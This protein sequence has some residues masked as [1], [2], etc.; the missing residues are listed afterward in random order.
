MRP[1]IFLDRDGVII[2]NRSD[3]VKSCD[4]VI[5]IPAA[6]RGLRQIATSDYAIV[7]VTNQAAVGK[8]IITLVQA[9]EINRRVIKVVRAHGGRI[10]AA[11]LCPHRSDADCEC[12]KPK[13]GM[14]LRAA[15]DQGLDLS[16]S[17]MIGDA[18]TDMQTARAAGVRGILVRTGQ[19]VIELERCTQPVWFG[20][21]DDLS[22][23]LSSIHLGTIFV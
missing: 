16:S 19:G 11:Y 5:L 4:E 1:A 18:I 22:A 6:L 10:D 17:V 15:K 3:Y 23:A 8:G 7:V 9:E 12:R 13:P 2:E 21:V 20:I 14:L